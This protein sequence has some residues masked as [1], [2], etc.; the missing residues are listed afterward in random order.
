MK[1]TKINPYKY[2]ITINKLKDNTLLIF[3]SPFS[4]KWEIFPGDLAELND[5]HLLSKSSDF[6]NSHIKLNGY[7]NAWKINTRYIKEHFKSNDY[8]INP[9]KSISI[10]LMIYFKPH[11]LNYIGN[12]ISS[13][14]A[15]FLTII[16]LV[17]IIKKRYT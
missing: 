13:V 10:N 12:V 7:A 5:I 4:E 14:T 3:N 15:G 2:I 11:S 17:L 6:N 8:K 9:D 1:F 16:L